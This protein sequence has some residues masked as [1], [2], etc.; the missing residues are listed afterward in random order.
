M[1]DISSMLQMKII[2]AC[3]PFLTLSEKEVRMRKKQGCGQGSRIS[4]DRFLIGLLKRWTVGLIFLLDTYS[5]SIPTSFSCCLELLTAVSV[6]C[7]S[8][9]AVSCGFTLDLVPLVGSPWC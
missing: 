7:Y 5:L 2:S 3:V 4:R 8:C 6:V 1:E 9:P